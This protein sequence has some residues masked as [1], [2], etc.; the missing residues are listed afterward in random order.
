MCGRTWK[1]K[2]SDIE[3][4]LINNL[5][6]AHTYLQNAQSILKL[7]IDSENDDMGRHL[8]EKLYEIG[9]TDVNMNYVRLSNVLKGLEKVMARRKV[10]DQ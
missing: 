7:L 5:S 9:I 2:M 4:N 3:K 8:R 6:V 1:W 10:P